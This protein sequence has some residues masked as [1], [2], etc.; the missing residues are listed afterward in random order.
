LQLGAV[1]VET[2]PVEA[3]QFERHAAVDDFG[4]GPW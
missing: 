4:D 1:G 3:F 2:D